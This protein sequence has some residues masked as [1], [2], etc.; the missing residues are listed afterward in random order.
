MV[1]HGINTC[2]RVRGERRPGRKETG[3]GNTCPVDQEQEETE[4]E[5]E[6][7]GSHRDTG[8]VFVFS[9]YNL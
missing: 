6:K 3:A 4:T 8:L 5:K 7:D 2:K 1:R 9:V